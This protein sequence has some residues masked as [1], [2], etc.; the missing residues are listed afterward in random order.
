TFYDEGE[1][2]Q[3]SIDSVS[4][5]LILGAV[6]AMIVLFFF[7]RNLKTPLIIGIS[8]PFSVIVTFA[9]LYF[10]D[11]SLN[12]M[13]L[14]GLALGIVM[15]VDISIV[16]IENISRH[17]GMGKEPKVAAAEG[18]KEVGG[19]ITASTL[20][21]IV[22]FLPIVFIS[23]IV[24]NIFTEFAL[25][26]AFSLIA[27]LFVALTVVPM[28]ASRVLTVP[29]ENKEIKRQ[30]SKSMAL[31]ERSVNWVLSHR[32]ITILIVTVLLAVGGLGLARTG[33][34]FLP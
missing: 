33:V 18:T 14:G 8:I 22:V 27:S 32:F 13:T 21:T 29:D 30:E 19:A 15:L 4:S 31:I 1:F 17:L 7:L 26:I 25:T 34:N 20:T 11:V 10:T 6:F 3:Q 5:A 24:G 16:V 2:V 12:I 23:G 28:I 9:F